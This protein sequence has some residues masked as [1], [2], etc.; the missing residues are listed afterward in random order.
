MY[1]DGTCSSVIAQDGT[2][3]RSPC[4]DAYGKVL[5]LSDLRAPFAGYLH[6][7]RYLSDLFILRDIS[8]FSPSSCP[9][10]SISSHDHR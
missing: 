1:R 8:L 6:R 7:G 9:E 3:T 10:T 2:V 4:P 5:G